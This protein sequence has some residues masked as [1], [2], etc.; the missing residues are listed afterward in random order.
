MNKK[1]IIDLVMSLFSIAGII[2]LYRFDLNFHREWA[3]ELPEWAASFFVM[4]YLPKIFR[5]IFILL[6]MWSS[7]RLV[8]YTLL[9]PSFLK[10][11]FKRIILI[12]TSLCLLLLLLEGIFGFVAISNQNWNALAQQNWMLY[13]A[14]ELNQF[15]FRDREIKEEDLKKKKI[16]VSG[17]SF[18][19]GDGVKHISG[20]YAGQLQKLLPPDWRVFNVSKSG[21]G[22]RG[23]FYH[24]TQ[25]PLK[26]DLIILQYFPN[27]LMEDYQT[28]KMYGH[29]FKTVSHSTWAGKVLGKYAYFFNFLYHY[30]RP[31]LSAK[32]GDYLDMLTRLYRN[33]H[34]CAQHRQELATIA[35][36]AREN[37][38][39]LL[40]LY[41]PFLT[42][43]N[44]DETLYY[45]FIRGFCQERM[46]PLVNTGELLDGMPLSER[47]V[48][49]WDHHPS[50]KLHKKT[51]E[52]LFMKIR[53]LGYLK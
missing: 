22:L 52:L 25:F 51:A 3:Q 13:Y 2:V 34:L 30:M 23:K 7:I 6:L 11:I 47:I 50:K 31:G 15:G 29:E 19:R 4:I 43:D 36:F 41:F 21:V 42:E 10:P 38:V 53:A 1:R 39:P 20:T 5:A 9:K 46:I 14:K 17:D 27:D 18:S 35:S 32:H 16:L 44:P 49:R 33:E 8:F 12:L 28:G 26:P 40:L 45:Q 24:I 48:N 37:E